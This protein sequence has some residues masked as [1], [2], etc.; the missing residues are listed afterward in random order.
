MNTD[1]ILVAYATRFGSTQE[2]AE[3]IAAILREAGVE[4]DT[5]T[6]QEVKGLDGYHAVVLGAAIYNTRWHPRAHQFLAEHQEALKQ[7]PTAIFALG[8]L[9]TSDIAMQRSRRQLDKELE[10]H[11]WLK[12]AALEM[13]VGKIDPSKLGFFERIGTT[14]SDNRNWS[15]IRNWAAALP[16]KLE[17]NKILNPS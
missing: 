12:P 11:P 13:F 5:Q 8:P 4:V 7:R 6:M 14:A 16:E 15:A 17:L 3:T 2:V 10:K 9:S 1:K